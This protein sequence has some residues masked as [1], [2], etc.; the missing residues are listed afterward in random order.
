MLLLAIAVIASFL[1]IIALGGVEEPSSSATESVAA[2]PPEGF[3]LVSQAQGKNC[4]TQT[5]LSIKPQM[6]LAA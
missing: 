5:K 1:M 4:T 3:E 2:E 6:F